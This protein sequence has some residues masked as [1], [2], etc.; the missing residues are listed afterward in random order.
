MITEEIV[1]KLAQYA[2]YLT[3]I[4][5]A[6]ALFW[7]YFFGRLWT[8]TKSFYRYSKTIFELL[9]MLQEIFE[10]WPELSSAHASDQ[11]P[12]G[13]LTDYILDL[14]A[15]SDYGVARLAATMDQR[16][17]PIYECEPAE[18]RCIYA[19]HSICELFGLEKAEFLG[20]GWLAAVIPGDRERVYQ[21]WRHAVLNRLPYECEYHIKNVRSGKRY[22]ITTKAVP[23]FDSSQKLI[24]Y[25]GRFLSV[26]EIQDDFNR[27]ITNHYPDGP[28]KLRIV[29]E[30]GH[31]YN[32]ANNVAG[33]QF[34][35]G[36]VCRCDQCED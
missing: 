29:L 1:S 2:G 19:N 25:H 33:R 5:G 27:Q 32:V 26:K 18:G 8:A 14:S 6:A 10:K 17:R 12:G 13:S 11:S 35:A 22:H 24:G 3:V 15:R 36:G 4:A 23:M 34:I 20:S 7:R 16:D 28:D 31:K 9:P 21:S 30:C